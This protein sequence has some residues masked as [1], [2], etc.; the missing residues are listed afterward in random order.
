M[1]LTTLTGKKC[2][3]LNSVQE[4]VLSCLAATDLFNMFYTINKVLYILLPRNKEYRCL[5]NKI[6]QIGS[7]NE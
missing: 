7:K 5:K 4:R 1:H 6:L 2:I 3:L